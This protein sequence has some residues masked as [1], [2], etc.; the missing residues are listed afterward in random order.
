LITPPSDLVSTDAPRVPLYSSEF[1]A[2]PHGAY[3][4]MRRKYGALVPV[5]LS[6]GVPATLVIGY[7]A[8]LAILNDPARF[9][10][11]PRAWEVTVPTDSPVLEVLRWRP[12]AMRSAG[13]DHARLRTVVS[14]ALDE[15]D[16][17]TIQGVVQRT[18]VPLINAFCTTGAANLVTQYAGPLVFMVINELLGCP[19]EI[20]RRAAASVAAI[21]DGTDSQDGNRAFENAV[22]HLVAVKRAEPG[23]DL[24]TSL[25]RHG[26]TLNDEEILQQLLVFYGIG[27]E[28][29]QNL[30]TNTLRL[31][32]I[33]DRFGDGVVGGALSTRD[34]LDQALFEDPPLPN[35]SIT[36][37]RQPILIDGVWLPAN[38]PVIVS[39]AGC[40]RDPEIAT[41]DH[42][43]NRS[44]LA[45][46]AGT[47]A[48]PA[49]SM[50]Y[51]MAQ[52]AVD[53]LLD[54]LP[55]LRLAVAGN[56]LQWRPGLFQRALA[57][58]PVTFEPAPLMPLL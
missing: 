27:M 58:L 36:Y 31:L 22:R 52:S 9:P 10:A 48:C 13:Q 56:E 38:Q 8:G 29:V 32:L 14:T 35:N 45:F 4:E 33:D 15:L 42:I 7:R 19:P 30:I 49:R 5:E 53:Q 50:A 51:L 18:A 28:P 23:P 26:S 25:L 6:P 11:D 44:H 1:S 37:P 43:G 40:N 17:H 39:A 2:D 24:T 3:L 41:G 46:S 12:I 20:S 16:L 57:E 34:A 47:H 54:A 21:L 55:E